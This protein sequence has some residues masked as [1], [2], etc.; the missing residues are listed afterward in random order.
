MQSEAARSAIGKGTEWCIRRFRPADTASTML[1]LIENI[2]PPCNRCEA[3]KFYSPSKDSCLDTRRGDPILAGATPQQR[4]G[5]P[6]LT[7]AQARACEWHCNS[8]E[9][10]W[11]YLARP[12]ISFRADGPAHVLESRSERSGFDAKSIFFSTCL[13]TRFTSESEPQR[14][15]VYRAT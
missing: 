8:A 2:S 7:S 5:E 13:P 4:K 9:S 6:R 14:F 12:S 10:G 15:I 1:Q 11:T 3:W